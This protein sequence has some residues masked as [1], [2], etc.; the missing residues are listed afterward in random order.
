MMDG[1][2]AALFDLD[3]TLV[4]AKDWHREAFN[5]ALERI[6]GFRLGVRQMDELEAMTTNDK[7]KRLV[8]LGD[9]HAD[10]VGE[11]WEL[12]QQYT[13]DIVESTAALDLSKVGMLEWLD[14]KDVRCAVVTNCT[15][16]MTELMLEKT[17]QL[18]HFEF[19]V[20]NSDVVHAKPCAEG[21]VRA[22][23]RMQVMP[24][25]CVIV[26]DSERGLQAAHATGAHVMRVADAKSLTK[27]SLERFMEGLR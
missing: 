2:K 7:L 11:I 13:R 18:Q 10:Q 23:V 21:Y 4:E 3:G 8:G 9:V 19:I 20:G 24:D 12:K 22:M 16:E 15:R 5:Q 1:I 6:S 17:G 14:R 27:Q 25:E 26:E